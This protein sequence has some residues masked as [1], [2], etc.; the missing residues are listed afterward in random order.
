[1]DHWNLI[2]ELTDKNVLGQ[3]G[4]S[5]RPPRK[6]ARAI[7]MNEDGKYAIV[8]IVYLKGMSTFS[9]LPQYE[10]GNRFYS[11]NVLKKEVRTEI[12]TIIRTYLKSK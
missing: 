2:A 3:E 4:F 1:M 10:V 12:G 5:N 7:L 6:T 9:W 8:D 11:F